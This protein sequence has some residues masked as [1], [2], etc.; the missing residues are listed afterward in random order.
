MK[1]KIISGTILT[2]KPIDRIIEGFRISL[3]NHG[4]SNIEIY[5]NQISAENANKDIQFSFVVS[6]S[7]RIFISQHT[8][9]LYDVRIDLDWRFNWLAW[10][11]ALLGLCTGLFL[12]FPILFF[13]VDPKNIYEQMIYDVQRMVS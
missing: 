3:E 6:I 7:T 10:L 13:F 9:T 2:D 8:D 4:G 12:I 5:G 11:G 1:S